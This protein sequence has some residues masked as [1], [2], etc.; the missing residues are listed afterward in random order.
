MTEAS[1][2]DWEALK[3][4]PGE[5]GRFTFTVPIREERFDPAWAQALVN[6]A[7]PRGLHTRPWGSVT[8]LERHV[9]VED[10][11]PG[12]EKRLRSFLE[13][14]AARAWEIAQQGSDMRDA[15]SSEE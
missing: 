9:E 6:E 11:A 12:S 1:D 3:T 2:F 4:T 13:D 14:V 10:V 5:R 7:E 8:I 15:F